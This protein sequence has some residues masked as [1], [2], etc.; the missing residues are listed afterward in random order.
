METNFGVSK[1]IYS[2]HLK[3]HLKEV[4]L[5]EHYCHLQM[6]TEFKHWTRFSGYDMIVPLSVRELV[7]CESTAQ[8]DRVM[9][10]KGSEINGLCD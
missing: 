8:K 3:P 4:I 2:S 7:L 5:F 10:E 9:G 6:N 1:A